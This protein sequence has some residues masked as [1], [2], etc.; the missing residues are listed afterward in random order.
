MISM[1][2]KRLIFLMIIIFL[3]QIFS[4]ITIFS[5][6]NLG[7]VVQELPLLENGGINFQWDIIVK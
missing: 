6:L 3:T 4:K 1:L 2:V 5:R 7:H